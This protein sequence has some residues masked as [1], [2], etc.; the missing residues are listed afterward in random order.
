MLLSIKDIRKSFTTDGSGQPRIVLNGVSLEIDKG[1][2]ISILGPS[3]SGKS[4]L[5]NIIGA[6]D[7]PDSGRVVFNGQT[8]EQKTDSEL[9][10]FRNR[11]LGF[12]FQL[13]HLLPQC[14]VLENVLLPVLPVKDKEIRKV[15]EKMALD[16]IKKVDLWPQKDQKPNILSGGECQRAA[17]IR[18][19]I[20][21]PELILADEP[22]GS[23]DEDNAISII[24]LLLDLNKQFDTALVVV[25]HSQEI[26]RRMEKIFEL[27]NGKLIQKT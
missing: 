25:T 11:E 7:K 27:K 5:L 14:T 10:E 15:R 24:S 9:T 20:N 19:L 6:L 8:I 18:A 16:L 2:T 12:V 21:Q 3:G 23:L 17:V 4:T 22:T 1:E 26:G 13:H